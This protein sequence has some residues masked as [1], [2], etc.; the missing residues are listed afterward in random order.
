MSEY[1]FGNSVENIQ[2]TE[3]VLSEE[4]YR[5]LLDY[6]VNIKDWHQ[7]PWGVQYY[8][9]EK[10]MSVEIVDILEK[11][12][13]LAHQQCTDRYNVN[14]RVFGKWEVHLVR[15]PAEF[16]MNKHIDTTGDFA[17]IY[18]INDNYEGGEINFP[19]HD[20]KIKPKPNSFVMFPSNKDYLHEVLKTI[21]G[22][23]YSSTL[24]FNI[25]GTPYRGNINET[26]GTARTVQ[27]GEKPW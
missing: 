26:E 19:W 14:L 27:Y 10:G 16:H 25:E 3:N 4:E 8:N 1:E 11:V 5:K 20:L 15:F 21:N 12:F 2:V 7:Q 6:T 13:R 18:Y 9:S 22:T 24:W 17:V 23:R